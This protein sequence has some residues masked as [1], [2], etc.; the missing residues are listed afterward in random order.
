MIE[1]DEAKAAVVTGGAGLIGS[2]VARRLAADGYAVAILDSNEEA[3]DSL[4]RELSSGGARSCAIAVDAC[5][6]QSV[7]DAF[8]QVASCV[9]RYDVMVHCVGTQQRCSWLDDPIDEWERSISLNLDSAYLCVQ[10]AANDMV[11]GT[12]PGEI[13]FILSDLAFNQDPD[14]MFSCAGTWGARGL[15]R[16]VARS[17]AKYGVRV[18]AVCPGLVEDRSAS[19]DARAALREAARER[20]ALGRPQTP[21]DVAALVSFLVREG[22]SITGQ[23][24][25]VAGGGAYA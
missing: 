17:L 16:N 25:P 7:G 24:L 21:E 1:T 15:M 6:R 5:D 12:V 14:A 13:I 19:E 4:A 2:A 3:A 18:N 8:D 23:S 11:A 22:H 20:F 9:G 10:R